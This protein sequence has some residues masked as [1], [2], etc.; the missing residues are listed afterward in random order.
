MANVRLDMA[1]PSFSTIKALFAKSRN[2]CA[3]PG[4]IAPLVESTETVTG[5]IC[6][7]RAEK[8]RGPRYE[9]N[10][11]IERLNAS[12]NLLLMCARHHK[13]IDTETEKY[14]TD[15]LLCLKREHEEQ[16]VVDISPS[17][18]KDA[19]AL[20]AHHLSITVTSNTGPV[21]INSP[22]SIQ[23]ETLNIKTTRPKLVVAAPIGSIGASQ[24]MSAYCKYLIARY[25]EYQ[26]ADFTAKSN[27]KYMALPNA[28][29]RKFGNRWQ[30]LPESAFDEV[31]AFLKARI[32]T[33]IIG[34]R[35]KARS[36]RNY[37]EFH[38][39]VR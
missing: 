17:V 15:V 35:N 33:T 19:E 37:H 18:A 34:R 27:Y 11:P 36:A 38:E 24:P 1:Q 21:S 22:G 28:V 31:S 7:I 13:I 26:K 2:R 6:H 14:S 8:D 16:G 3:F 23:A 4:C 32:D 29:M 20:L 10:F 39:H 25:N 9:K 12:E 30:D 5:Q